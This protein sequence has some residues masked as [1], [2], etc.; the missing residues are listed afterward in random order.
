MDTSAKEDIGID[1][2][3]YDMGEMLMKKK[4]KNNIQQQSVKLTPTIIRKKRNCMCII[5]EK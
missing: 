5:S 4:G 2:I 1:K 3:F